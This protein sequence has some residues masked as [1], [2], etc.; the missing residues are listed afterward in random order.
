MNLA[1]CFVFNN[2]KRFDLKLLILREFNRSYQRERDK[3]SKFMVEVRKK[4]REN[5]IKQKQLLLEYKNYKAHT[6][7]EVNDNCILI[8]LNVN[9]QSDSYFERA[10]P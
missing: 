10:W 6:F 8:F 7:Q 1:S 3:C 4:S 2:I 5:K 9:G